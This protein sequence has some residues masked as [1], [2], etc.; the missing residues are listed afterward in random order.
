[1]RILQVSD[2]FTPVRGGLESH[3]DDL[4]CEL[5]RRGHEVH[6]ATMTANPAPSSDDV[7]VHVVSNAASRLISYADA[8]RPF[9]LP[10]ADPVARRDL[11]TVI[12]EVRPD[13]IHAHSWLA[14]SLPDVGVPVVFTA[15]DYA[16]VCQ[17]HTLLRTD[18]E[19]CGGQSFAA[20][21]RCARRAHGT[22]RAAA[23]AL[24]VPFGRNRLRVDLVLTLS[25]QVRR[26]LVGRLRMPVRAVG[27]FLPARPVPQPSAELPAAPFVMYAGDPGRHK[28]IDLLINMWRE[29]PPP[30]SL[31]LAVT[32]PLS[33][34]TP[35]NVDVRTLDRTAVQNAWRR[36]AVA[37]VPSLWQ[38]PYGMVAVEALS[39]GTP[40]V[41]FASGALTELVRDGV[42]GVL[43]SPGDAVALQRAVT[44]LLNDDALRQR[45][46]AAAL[47][48]AKRFTADVVVPRIE[49]AYADVTQPQ[50]AGVR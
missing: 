40:V 43:V 49:Q 38:E 46:S 37:I 6:V 27:G 36:A 3:V 50:L 13:V 33:R 34:P 30:A 32:R 2:F 18:G 31:L 8:D 14:A 12:D 7:E 26:A 29:D 19:Q 39:A 5:S 23:L 42:D 45:M 15:H 4:A 22:A 21:T 41:A 11:R 16:L 9:H 48:G 47:D 20:C 28:G 17:L 35:P 25:E 44:T 24:G 1:M 10:T